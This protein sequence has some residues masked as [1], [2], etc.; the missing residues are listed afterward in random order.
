MDGGKRRRCYPVDDYC[1]PYEKLLSL[2][3]WNQYLK[4]G[5]SPDLLQRQVAR[6]SDTEAA[7][8]MQTAKTALLA[9]CRPSR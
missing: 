1:T 4:E 5:I 2:P 8:H 9:K 7:Q 6:M 3:D